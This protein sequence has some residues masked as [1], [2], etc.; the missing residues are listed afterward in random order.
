MGILQEARAPIDFEVLDLQ[1]NAISPEVVA[2]ISRNEVVLKGPLYKTTGDTSRNTKLR[3]MFNLYA[4]V[5][6][7]KS[8]RSVRTR[9]EDVNLVIVRL[10]LEGEYSNMENEIVPGVVQH[11]K[12]TTEIRSRQ[13]ATYAFELARTEGRKK[14]TAIHKA[15]IQKLTDGLFL[16][17]CRAVAKNYADIQYEEMIVDNAAMQMV[18]KPSQFDVIVTPN[19]YGNILTNIAVG[20]VGGP[21]LVP[22]VNKGKHI[23]MFEPGARHTGADIAGKGIANPTAMILASTMLLRHIGLDEHAVKIEAALERVL[24]EKNPRRLTPDLGG[25]A[26]TKEFTQAIMASLEK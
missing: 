5:V 19:L 24:A 7:V 3:D 2:S 23:A 26:S 15:N 4:N 25:S 21:G 11:L 22:G 10:N 14:V 9:H 1:P 18:M 6:P 13:I 12:V 8:F 16:E 20:L 17:T